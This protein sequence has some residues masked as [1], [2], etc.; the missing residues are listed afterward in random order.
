MRVL[1]PSG[2]RAIDSLKVGEEV[3]SWVESTKALVANRIAEVYASDDD[4]EF[5]Q[6]VDLSPFGIPL[7]VTADHPFYSASAE[8]YVPLSEIAEG[9][10]RVPSA[11]DE[12]IP[13]A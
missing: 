7:E 3:Y 10:I 9:A 8:G 6:L 11:K 13:F 2:Y 12:C 1:T 4:V 5:G